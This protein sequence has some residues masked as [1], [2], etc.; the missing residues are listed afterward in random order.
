MHHRSF[1]RYPIG[2]AVSSGGDADICAAVAS[3]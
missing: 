2:P 3:H 1:Q